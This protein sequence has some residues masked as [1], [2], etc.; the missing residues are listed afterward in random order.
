MIC[1]GGQDL[2][3]FDQYDSPREALLVLNTCAIFC[4]FLYI[5]WKLKKLWQHT[6]ESLPKSL[7]SSTP[8]VKQELL[9][10]P[11]KKRKKEVNW[12]KKKIGV[13][14]SITVNVGYIDKNIREKKIEG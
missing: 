6:L 12:D 9:F 2:G 1:Q 13:G 14:T 3:G 10:L 11:I 8:L 7:I 5:F 4:W